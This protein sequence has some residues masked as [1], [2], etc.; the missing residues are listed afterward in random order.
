MFSPPLSVRRN[1]LV[2]TYLLAGIILGASLVLAGQPHG[3][4]LYLA[5]RLWKILLLSQALAAEGL[6][7]LLALQ[8]VP[9]LVGRIPFILR[10]PLRYGLLFG[11]LFT[12]ISLS[13]L[14]AY[15]FI[16]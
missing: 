7:L 12:L 14:L 1:R 6:L 8:Y 4:M 5:P 9:Q 16:A 3:H 10:Q 15:Q 2:I 13:S 11:A